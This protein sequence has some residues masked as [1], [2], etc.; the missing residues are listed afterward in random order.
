ML[1]W[2][3]FM[4]NFMQH[5]MENFTRTR[6]QG[7]TQAPRVAFKQED[8]ENTVQAEHKCTNTLL[9]TVSEKKRTT[10]NLGTRGSLELE[11]ENEI[12]YSSS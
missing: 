2:P 6:S 11:Q 3:D 7:G 12:G 8:A 9:R 1:N 5:F 4:E 10:R